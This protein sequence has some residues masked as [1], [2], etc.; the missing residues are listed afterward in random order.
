VVPDACT[1]TVDCR[2]TPEFDNEAMI[3]HLEQAAE[4]EGGRFEVRSSRFRPVLTP[5][6]EP[7]VHAA[8]A[9]TGRDEATVFPSVC[10]LF[11]VAHVPSIVSGP[12]R[13]ERSHQADEFV[14][15]DEVVAGVETYARM[16]EAWNRRVRGA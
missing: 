16:A 6:D 2:T 9:A 4:S 11:W 12:G 1:L 15:V 13:P 3:A 8:L 7:I 14:R 10:D 5:R